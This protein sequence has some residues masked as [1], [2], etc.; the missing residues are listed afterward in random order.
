M[1]HVRKLMLSRPYVTRI[2]DQSLIASEVG[3]GD[4]RLSATR[5]QDGSYA[6]VYIPLGTPVKVHLDKL[7]GKSVKAWWQGIG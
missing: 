1:T 7:S 3:K 5:H 2:P 6:F 4:G